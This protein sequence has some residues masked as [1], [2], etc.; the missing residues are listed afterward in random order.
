MLGAGAS[1]VL[2]TGLAA[3]DATC[4]QVRV[5]QIR[6]VPGRS[7]TTEYRARISWP[8]GTT[9]EDTVVAAAGLAVTGQV[10]VVD[11]DGVEVS[12]WRY[13]ND[14]FLPGLA[15]GADRQRVMKLLGDLGAPADEVRLRRRAYRAGRRAVIEATTPDAHLFLKILR[16]ERT[17]RVFEA[18]DRLV[19]ALPVPRSHGWNEE[20]GIITLQAVGG[21]PLRTM[22]EKGRR[23]LPS[24][25]QIRHLLDQFPEANNDDLVASNPLHRAEEHAR[26]LGLVVPDIRGRLDDLAGRLAAVPTSADECIHGDFHS[27]QILVEGSEIVGLV[28]IDTAGRGERSSDYAGLL[29]HLSVLGVMARR[30]GDIDRYG[31]ELISAF[32]QMVD[33]VGLRMRTAAA[34]LGLATGP[35][36][37]QEQDWADNTR[38]RLALAER[39]AESALV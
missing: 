15:V 39:W 33:P 19:E 2:A 20:L 1:A 23:R 37:V 36:R 6:Y 32:D 25:D 12:L 30:R 14:P 16:P 34:V 22:L 27:S 24:A 8:D 7:V 5:S 26:L 38:A 17:R 21:V 29:A 10:A 13:P 35:F 3:L 11:A 31:R 9:T 28:D 18:H 4:D